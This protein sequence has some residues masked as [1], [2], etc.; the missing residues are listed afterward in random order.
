[1]GL[2][3]AFHQVSSGRYNTVGTRDVSKRKI[4]KL[5]RMNASI[6]FLKNFRVSERVSVGQ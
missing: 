4:K 2:L 6:S 3:I 5:A 1:L